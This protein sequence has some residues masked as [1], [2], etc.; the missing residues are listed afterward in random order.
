MVDERKPL[1]TDQLAQR[2]DISADTLQDWRTDGSGPTYFRLGNPKY[3]SP[4]YSMD[5]IE[6]YERTNGIT[7][8]ENV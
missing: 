7:P 3:G 2:W 4:R 5:A 8:K 1:T 6:E